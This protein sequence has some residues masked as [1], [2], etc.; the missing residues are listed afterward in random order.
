MSSSPTPSEEGKDLAEEN[1][2][3]KIEP[4]TAKANKGAESAAAI[5]PATATPIA[6]APT[7]NSLDTGLGS[8]T[9][10]KPAL[11]RRPVGGEDEVSEK[12]GVD[13]SPMSK[14]K[15]PAS[16][17]GATMALQPAAG[18]DTKKG[19]PPAVDASRDD[20][21]NV[22]IDITSVDVR[23]DASSA[24]VFAATPALPAVPNVADAPAAATTNATLVPAAFKAPAQNNDEQE[25]HQAL[26]EQ[27][28]LQ[29]NELQ[30][31]FDQKLLEIQKQN[32]DRFNQIAQ[33]H[34]L[35]SSEQRERERASR[36][37]L[38]E[39]IDASEL[40]ASELQ[41]Q[42][43]TSGNF[44]MDVDRLQDTVEEAR[45]TT[46][47]ALAH[48]SSFGEQLTRAQA[49]N[50]SRATELA[51]TKARVIALEGEL[52]KS[53]IE[54][55][56]NMHSAASSLHSDD[57]DETPAGIAASNAA[58]DR[59]WYAYARRSDAEQQ[60][61]LARL[62]ALQRKVIENDERA[63]HTAVLLRQPRQAEADDGRTTGSH[64]FEQ[65]ART[66]A[67]RADAQRSTDD[68]ATARANA[69]AA[70]QAAAARAN[71]AAAARAN[72]VAAQ[73][74]EHAARARATAQQLADEQNQRHLEAA[75]EQFADEQRRVAQERAAQEKLNFEKALVS[76]REAYQKE[77]EQREE[78]LVAEYRARL[79]QAER[80]RELLAS[81][82][83]YTNRMFNEYR[84]HQ[85]DHYDK[86][87]IDHRPKPA[88]AGAAAAV[89]YAAVDDYRPPPASA[90]TTTHSGGV[91]TAMPYATAAA[92]AAASPTYTPAGSI[93]RPLDMAPP[94]GGASV[95]VKVHHAPP[96]WSTAEE[97]S[98]YE[99]YNAACLL[100]ARRKFEAMTGSALWRTFADLP[101]APQQMLVDHI[102]NTVATATAAP[103][104]L[105]KLT[106]IKHE[107]GLSSIQDIPLSNVA[108]CMREY[109][110]P[111]LVHKLTSGTVGAK[112]IAT[113]KL[114]NQ[115]L[116]PQLH[117][118]G[119]EEQY[120]EATNEA[121]ETIAD[122][123]A[124]NDP[125]H[126]ALI[127]Q[128]MNEYNHRT[129]ARNV[130]TELMRIPEMANYRD[131]LRTLADNARIHDD[132]S[133]V[134]KLATKKACSLTTVSYPLAHNSP[135]ADSMDSANVWQ[136]VVNGK[137]VPANAKAK[138]QQ[139]R[140]LALMKSSRPWTKDDRSTVC[141]HYGTKEVNARS[142]SRCSMCNKS[143]AC[144]PECTTYK[145]ANRQTRKDGGSATP[146]AAAGGTKPI[147]C[148][149]CNVVTKPSHFSSHCDEY[150][151]ARATEVGDV[152]AAKERSAGV[153]WRG[154]N[155]RDR[156]NTTA[157]RAETT[158]D[159]DK[160]ARLERENA[161]LREGASNFARQLA[162]TDETFR[163][164]AEVSLKESNAEFFKT[165]LM[166]QPKK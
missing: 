87:G 5:N 93:R 13:G 57:E 125:E 28:S 133:E 1:D 72:A 52:E 107:H 97:G 131:Q 115:N 74:A 38:L 111:A 46:A 108:Q 48:A 130:V 73:Q 153:P 129:I 33:N 146:A 3:I 90:G 42:L 7:A 60:E 29:R 2:T 100:Y 82:E 145:A 152:Q 8:T 11:R 163:A 106:T 50:L 79:Q 51:L 117:V 123:S 161:E 9:L 126:L 19:V 128:I 95:V 137:A 94:P 49:E 104:L 54:R 84:Q 14:V 134:F 162:A 70:Q 27:L 58:D 15:T 12:L 65:R 155:A 26:A 88:N 105:T 80:Q 75:A 101:A 63:R 10:A 68:A 39:R 34:E 18:I 6:P 138:V 17:D 142:G 149:S 96:K 32:D 114:K 148:Y 20:T 86:T 122:L 35:Y 23:S 136:K 78:Q 141:K 102:C 24:S 147:K 110:F 61:E 120:N 77:Q 25:A 121:K 160:I 116:S 158:T 113:I 92:S 150:W 53:L 40:Q 45:G 59:D 44:M 30:T 157:D 31:I 85:A 139:D 119:F 156:A 165:H 41:H 91:T 127:E 103:W 166:P 112:T 47:Q 67:Q 132:V 76:S 140:A 109:C 71:E 16:S 151:K 99:S 69:G 4:T 66:E 83:R 81:P 56:S 55:S 118:R 36:D 21:T 159:H 37:R 164:A 98:A 124:S 89:Q 143:P 64:A 144:K 135:D 154:H 43:D 62:V 22:K